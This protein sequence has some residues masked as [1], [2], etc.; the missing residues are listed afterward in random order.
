MGTPDILGTYG[1]FTFYSGDESAADE[2]AVSGGR[3]VGAHLVDGVLHG[4][5]HGPP[6]RFA[7]GHRRPR[8]RSIFTSIPTG[9][10][11]RSSRARR[12]DCC[13]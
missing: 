10:W 8:R 2:I 1:T 12:S 3:I 11:Q 13:K 7:P 6:I 9:P 4:T 5:L